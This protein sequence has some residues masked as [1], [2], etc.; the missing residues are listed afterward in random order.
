MFEDKPWLKFYGK[1]TPES[2]EYPEVTLYGALMRTVARVPDAIAW[3]FMGRTSTYKPLAR[4]STSA[5]ACSPALAWV[6]AIGSRSRCPPRRK[7]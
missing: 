3:D 4:R 1:D 2:I 5:R 6:K 7:A